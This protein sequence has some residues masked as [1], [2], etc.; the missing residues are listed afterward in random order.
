MFRCRTA[1]AAIVLCLPATDL[2][3]AAPPAPVAAKEPQI[4]ASLRDA[5]EES[6]KESSELQNELLLEDSAPR[7]TVEQ[8]KINGEYQLIGAN[9]SLMGQ[10]RCTPFSRAIIGIAYVAP[11]MQCRADRLKGATGTRPESC[12]RTKW[13]PLG[14]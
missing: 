3:S 7:A 1:V 13:T 4:C 9:L 10:Y 5:I 12:D 11:A 8:L 6:E 14:K 2:A